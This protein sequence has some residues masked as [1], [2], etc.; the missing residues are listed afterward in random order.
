VATGAFGASSKHKKDQPKQM[1]RAIS[2]LQ[3]AR[4]TYQPK[5]P[6][7]LRAGNVKIGLGAPTEPATDKEEIK[8]LFPYTYGQPVAKIVA[9]EGLSSATPLKVGVVLSGGQAPGGHN[10]IAGLFDALKAANKENPVLR[11]LITSE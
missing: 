11:T 9:G 3:K 1:S 2:P 8:K 10:V 4:A 6:K 7:A 5:L